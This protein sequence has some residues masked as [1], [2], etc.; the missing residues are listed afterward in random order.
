MNSDGVGNPNSLNGRSYTWEHGRELATVSYNGTTW[1]N[2]YDANGMRI[3]RQSSGKTYS[4]VYNGGQLTE[5]SVDGMDLYFSYDASGRPLSLRYDNDFYYYMTNLQGDVVA[6]L[7]YLG[8]TVATYTYDAWGRS[9]V[10]TDTTAENFG[11][12][13][14]LRYRGYVYDT[15]T[16]LY[17]LQSRYYDPEINMRDYI[18]IKVS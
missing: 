16:G 1:T 17:Y 6:L 4:Y 9:L 12:L 2:T 3:R 11:S 7:N 18:L 8:E 10:T 14:P 5:M 13:N 15:E